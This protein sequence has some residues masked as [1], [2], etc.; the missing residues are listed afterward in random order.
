MTRTHCRLILLLLAFT[1]LMGAG[2]AAAEKTVTITFTGDCTLGSEEKTRADQYSFDTVAAKEGYDYFFANYREMFE[3]DDLTVIN[4]EGVLS[5]SKA[6]ESQ[7]KRYRFRGPTDFVKILTQNSVEAACLTNNHIGDYGKQGEKTTKETLTENGIAWFQNFNVYIYEK[8]GIKIAFMALENKTVYNQFD[9]VKSTI[10][11]LKKT[12][13]ANAVVICWHTGLEYRGAHEDNTDRTSKA[14]IKYGA[15][16]IIMHHP[17][18]VQGIDASNNRYIFYSLGNFV[19]GGNDE[20]REEKFLIDKKVTSLYSIV[21]Q[22]RLTFSNEGTYLGQQATVYPTYT[23]SGGILRE[24]IQLNNYQPFR[25]DAEQ[26]VPVRDAL[27]MDTKFELPE[28]TTDKNGLSK[29]EMPYLPAFEGAM[30]PESEGDEEA[31]SG[32]IGVPEAASAAP[33]R[34]NRGN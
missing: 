28:I 4:F 15:D 22:A 6:M 21:V 14:M 25:A 12:G 19:F 7:R 33:T 13:E 17:H 16:L 10:I 26:A 30:V 18:V 31:A 5:D 32:L 11:N 24:N 1:L 34:A 3:N 2:C 27:Q 20:I 9:K 23:S 8:D 29:I